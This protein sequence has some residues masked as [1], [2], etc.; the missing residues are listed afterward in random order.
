[1][2]GSSRF[3]L[4]LNLYRIDE[5]RGGNPTLEEDDSLVNNRNCD[6]ETHSIH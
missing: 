1:M 6:L 2:T 3:N 5:T 4:N